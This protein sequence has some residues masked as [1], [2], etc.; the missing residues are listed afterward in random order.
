LDALSVG[1]YEAE[2]VKQ[3]DDDKNLG[4]TRVCPGS[5]L[6]PF[7]LWI[8]VWGSLACRVT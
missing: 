2:T 6:F 4:S 7:I 3:V 5:L 1:P 8:F